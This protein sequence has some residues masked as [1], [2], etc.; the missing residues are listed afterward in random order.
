MYG[1]TQRPCESDKTIMGNRTL[2]HCHAM[3][4]PKDRA[5]MASEMGMDQSMLDRLQPFEW[6]EVDQKGTITRGKTKKPTV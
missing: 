6:V 5:Y 2:V 1:V 3:P 4:R